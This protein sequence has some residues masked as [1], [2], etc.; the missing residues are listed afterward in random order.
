ME[1]DKQIRDRKL[2]ELK[3]RKAKIQEMGG[4]ERVA[5][6]EKRGKLNARARIEL[7]LD[8]GSF[9]ETGMFVKSRNSGAYEDVNADAVVTG[10]GK[11]DDGKSI[12]ALRTSPAWAAQWLRSNPKKFVNYWIAPCAS[13]VP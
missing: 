8:K 12:F 2:A 11:I 4:K 13:G 10:Y 7:L 3:E 1:S 6:Q 9:H 5:A